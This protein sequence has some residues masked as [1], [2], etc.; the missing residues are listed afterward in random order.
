MDDAV[1]GLKNISTKVLVEEV[2]K[3]DGVDHCWIEPEE[4]A[5]LVHEDANFPDAIT[6]PAW[7]LIVTDR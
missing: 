1:F 4:R 2:M 3:R 6:G 7:V 5:S